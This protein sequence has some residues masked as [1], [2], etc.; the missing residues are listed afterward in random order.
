MTKETVVHTE[1]REDEL[2]PKSAAHVEE[3]VLA[4]LTE[5]DLLKLSRES[6]DLK[7]WA[8]LR[9]LGILL[10]M[11]CNQAGFGVD[12]AVIGGINAI[13]GWHDYFGFGTSGGTYGLLNALMNIGTV[14][15]SPF[16]SLSDVIGRRSVNFIGN[17]LVVAASIMQAQSPN[18]KVFMGGRFLM[19]FGSALLSSSQYIGEV[20]PVHLRGLYVGLFGA[21]FQIGSLVMTGAMISISQIE[22]DLAWRLPLYLNMVFPALVCL[23]LYTLCPESPRYYIMRGNRDAAKRV[24]A[25]YHTTSGDVDQPIVNIMVQQMEASVENDRAG[26]QSFWD[27]SVFF[28]KTVHYRLLV[29][30]LYS[31]FQ[32]WNGGGIITYYM[33]PALETIGVKDSMSQLGIQLGTTAVYFVFTAVGALII[34][35]LRRRTMIFVGLGTMILFQTTTTITSWQYDVTGSKAAAGLTILW[36]YLYQT[37]S[38][39]FI[40]TMHN[41]YPVEILSLPLRAKGMGLY[42]LIQ[43]GAGAVQTYGISQGINKIGYKIWVVYIVY[44]TIQL[45]LSYFVF[46]ETS[47]LSLEEIDAVFET[48]GVAPV[49][50]SKDIYKAKRQMEEANRD[51]AA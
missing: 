31:V 40:A 9:L 46:P 48:P 19:G 37:F 28:K 11:G 12:W 42:G 34:D 39:M 41:L 18:I 29:L 5:E 6:L 35:R 23:G 47:G 8:G 44:N 50:M 36:I 13:Q 15:G 20:S 43:G 1:T 26:H 45:V 3:A 21:C 33:V 27:Y 51:P 10:V 30:V 16:L 14:C 38:A 25:K 17:L 49:K 4:S 22:G 24:L 2:P 7:S 32:Q